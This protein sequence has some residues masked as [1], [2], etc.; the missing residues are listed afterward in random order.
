MQDLKSNL[1][2]LQYS[3]LISYLFFCFVNIWEKTSKIC[4]LNRFSVVKNEQVNSLC[5]ML[6]KG[7]CLTPGKLFSQP[8]NFSIYIKI[9]TSK[10]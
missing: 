5:D 1:M 8:L 2:V 7:A 6:L 4:L 9:E 3:Y 10:N